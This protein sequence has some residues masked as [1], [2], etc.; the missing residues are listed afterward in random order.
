M[1]F[2]PSQFTFENIKFNS[3]LEEIV[4]KT[5]VD[6]DC[7]DVQLQKLVIYGEGAPASPCSSKAG[8]LGRLVVQLPSLFTGNSLLVNHNNEKKTIQF[9]R[10]EAKYGIV[11]AAHLSNCGVEMAPLE[12]GFRTFL[13]YDLMSEDL[14]IRFKDFEEKRKITAGISSTL[15]KVMYLVRITYLLCFFITSK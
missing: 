7:K 10:K 11:Y 12:D 9:D 8:Q 2:G 1:E 13:V 4:S 5:K 15:S 14:E 6:L 3:S